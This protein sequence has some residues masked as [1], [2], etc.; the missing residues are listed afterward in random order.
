[1]TLYLD[2]GDLTGA[3]TVEQ[4][5][6]KPAGTLQFPLQA[7]GDFKGKFV[8]S[9]PEAVEAMIRVN[10]IVEALSSSH[11]HMTAAVTL[12]FMEG[13]IKTKAGDVL[14]DAQKIQQ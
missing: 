5:G 2:S 4:N 11:S 9:R 6:K 3:L 10:I 8:K 14:F 13:A 1:M 7:A 12:P